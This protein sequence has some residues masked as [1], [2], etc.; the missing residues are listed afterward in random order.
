MTQLRDLENQYHEF[1]TELALETLEQHV[2][3]QL[4]EELPKEL[5][6]VSG[7]QW[8]VWFPSLGMRPRA[9]VLE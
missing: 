7:H 9:R 1:L 6:G 8:L 2:K 3:K 4:D 5:A